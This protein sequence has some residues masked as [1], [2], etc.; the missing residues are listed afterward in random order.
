MRPSLMTIIRRLDKLFSK[1]QKSSKV[2]GSVDW[3]ALAALLRGVYATLWRHPYIV[4]APHLKSLVGTCQCIVV[5][6]DSLTSL[7]DHHHHSSSQ[8]GFLSNTGCLD[9]TFS[10]SIARWRLFCR[11]STLLFSLKLFL[12]KK[13]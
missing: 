11:C 7:T 6:E 4:N 5:G 1:I 3:R 9:K 13:C 10:Y 2:Y 12:L 8:G